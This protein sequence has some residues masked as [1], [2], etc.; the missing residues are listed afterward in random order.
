M[1]DTWV[2][3]LRHYLDERTGDIPD[4]LPGPALSVALFFGSIV[5]WVTDHLPEAEWHTN[6]SCRRSP[7]R[8]RCL[9]E[10]FAELDGGTGQIV[11]RCPRCGD[12]GL[13][14]GWE[15]TVWN[16]QDGSA[17]AASIDTPPTTS[18]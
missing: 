11:W 4:S 17:L 7:G 5:A 18:H 3:D 2:V 13:I 12:N 16:R 10:I 15:D 9:G 6:V 8:R 14:H 1:G